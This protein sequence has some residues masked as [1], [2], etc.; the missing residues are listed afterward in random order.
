V[1]VR[2]EGT[3]ARRS[4]RPSR[5]P[6][7]GAR[8]GEMIRREIICEIICGIKC[9]KD[10]TKSSQKIITSG[11]QYYSPPPHTTH[12]R[13]RER[14]LLMDNSRSSILAEK[15]ICMYPHTSNIGGYICIYCKMREKCNAKLVRTNKRRKRNVSL[16]KASQAQQWSIFFWSK[17]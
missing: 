4:N 11:Q 10:K 3:R 15:Y 2:V 7:R 17:N 8:P 16:N 5:L 6:S 9:R 14:S 1:I 12:N 13:E